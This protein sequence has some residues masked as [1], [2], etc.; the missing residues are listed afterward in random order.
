MKLF[1]AGQKSHD[2]VKMQRDL[3]AN[4]DL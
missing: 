4:D 2:F 1:L 3:M